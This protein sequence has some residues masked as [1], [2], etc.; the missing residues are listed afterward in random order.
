MTIILKLRDNQDR[1]RIDSTLERLFRQPRRQVEASLRY[2]SSP[3]HRGTSQSL[4]RYQIH[5]TLDRDRPR[6]PHHPRSA[7]PR[8][9][10]RLRPPHH[11]DSQTTREVSEII[12][13]GRKV[14]RR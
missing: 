11:P 5:P 2:G 3:L 14:R 7:L 12:R 8:S 1:A 13:N 9:R 6:R 4:H 10:R